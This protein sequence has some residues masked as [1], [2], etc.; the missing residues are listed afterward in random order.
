MGGAAVKKKEWRKRNMFG[1]T[2]KVHLFA[3]LRGRAQSNM[4][5]LTHGPFFNFELYRDSQELWDKRLGTTVL[6][7]ASLKHANTKN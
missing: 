5:R 6:L 2:A 7:K 3:K 1:M 4:E